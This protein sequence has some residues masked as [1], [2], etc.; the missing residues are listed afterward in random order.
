MRKPARVARGDDRAEIVRVI[1]LLE[2]LEEKE[3]A[4]PLAFDAARQLD[5]EAQVAALAMVMAKARDAGATLAIGK[6]ASQRGFP[7]DEHAFP[8]FG[9]PNYEPLA[10]SAEKPMVY[11]IA[12]QES[13]FAPKAL[14]TA[15]AKGLMQMM[16]P[17]ARGTAKKAGVPFDEDRLIRDAAFN[18]QLGAA[19]LA[20]LMGEYRN[21]NIL[22]FA[23]YNAGGRRVKEWI[24]AHGDPRDPG[25]DPIDWVELIPIA[26]TR[27]YVQRI[28][29]NLEVY[30]VRLGEKRTFAIE[31]T[32]RQA[33]ARR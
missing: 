31:D 28:V 29:E 24:T 23:A 11:A 19:H 32:L 20:D 5:D 7:L 13:A 3:I 16:T 25:V 12:R 2:A 10:R 9:V 21:S 15:G 22:T 6:I 30:R 8:D 17:T 18:A 14:S 1:E 33:V 4:R 26:E 27:N